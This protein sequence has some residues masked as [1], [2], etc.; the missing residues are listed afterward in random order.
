MPCCTYFD[1]FQ[2]EVLPPAISPVLRSL[3][4]LGGGTE[5]KMNLLLD[6]LAASLHE[7]NAD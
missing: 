5:E 7:F 1:L 2:V 3:V 6:Q 4:A